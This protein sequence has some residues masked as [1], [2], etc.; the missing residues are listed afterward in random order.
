MLGAIFDIDGTLVDSL[1]VWEKLWEMLG[2]RYFGDKSFRPSDEDAKS[3]RTMLLADVIKNVSKKYNMTSN[4][5][6]ALEFLREFLHHYYRES[7]TLKNGCIELLEALTKRGVKLGV[8]SANDKE[9]LGYVLDIMGI[10]KYFSCVLSCDDVGC[11]KERPDV[12]VAAMNALGTPLSETAVF[13]DSVT[14]VETAKRYGFKVVGIFDKNNH[15][16]ER[17]K[18]LS[19]VYVGEEM[20]LTAALDGGI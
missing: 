12:Y 16:Q 4:D 8:A 2:E 15:S 14:A 18:A 20:P 6:D 10:K 17:I 9:M 3:Y 7:V 19:D 1:G 13:E 5:A 11:G